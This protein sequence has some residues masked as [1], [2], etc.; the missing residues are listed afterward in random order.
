MV[1]DE[2]QIGLLTLPNEILDQIFVECFHPPRLNSPRARGKRGLGPMAW[3]TG[4]RSL[5]LVNS[6]LALVGKHYLAFK[7]LITSER[8]LQTPDEEAKLY[9]RF[10]WCGKASLLF[11]LPGQLIE[12]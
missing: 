11:T 3:E 1:A 12:S 2:L 10:T 6:H 7:L 8:Q 9:M 4:F 5:R